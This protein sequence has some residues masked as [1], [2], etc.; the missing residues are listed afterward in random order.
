MLDA[1]I[2][3]S[4]TASV[5]QLEDINAAGRAQ[6]LHRFSFGWIPLFSTAVF[7]L[8]GPAVDGKKPQPHLI[9]VG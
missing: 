8:T 2:D 7:Y 4:L 5:W 1:F 3:I 6:V 9:A